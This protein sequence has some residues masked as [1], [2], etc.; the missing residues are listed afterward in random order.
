M[1]GRRGSVATIDRTG[2]SPSRVDRAVPDGCSQSCVG[3]RK[4]LHSPRHAYAVAA[5]PPKIRRV[6]NKI[7]GTDV[8]PWPL[9]HFQPSERP[10]TSAARPTV[11]STTRPTIVSRENVVSGTASPYMDGC[12]Q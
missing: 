10:G 6:R 5:L 12:P 2:L 8:L 1:V 4:R 7:P 3:R 9:T 11:R